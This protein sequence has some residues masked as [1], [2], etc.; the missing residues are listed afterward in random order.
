VPKPVLS[1]I[2]MVD[3]PSL[4]FKMLISHASISLKIAIR[5]AN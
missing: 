4:R 2:I 3:G 5:Q 1:D